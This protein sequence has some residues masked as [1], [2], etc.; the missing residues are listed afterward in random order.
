MGSECSAALRINVFLDRSMYVIA[1]A[2]MHGRVHQQ[3]STCKRGITTVRRNKSQKRRYAPACEGTSLATTPLA[4]SEFTASPAPSPPSP[5]SV[6]DARSD[7]RS[8]ILQ[9]R[10]STSRKLSPGGSPTEPASPGNHS[11]R[12]PSTSPCRRQSP[13]PSWR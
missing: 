11:S 6:Y 3:R 1:K 12:R 8:A 9:E 10:V 13:T 7:F 4:A 2:C 5:G